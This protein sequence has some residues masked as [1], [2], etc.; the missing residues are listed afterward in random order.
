[1]QPPKDLKRIS[2]ELAKCSENAASNRN[3]AQALRDRALQYAQQGSEGKVAY[4]TSQ[5]EKLDAKAIKLENEIPKLEMAQS[6]IEK[7][8]SDLQVQRAAVAQ[9]SPERAAAIDTQIIQLRGA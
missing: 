6:M 8:V 4:D 3:Q 7:Q 9:Q 2:V 1:M 5:A